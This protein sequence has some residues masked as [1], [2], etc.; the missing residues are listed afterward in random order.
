MRMKRVKSPDPFMSPV[1]FPRRWTI[2]KRSSNEDR[3]VRNGR[4][5]GVE[6]RVSGCMVLV[7]HLIDCGSG[8][9]LL[10]ALGSNC[11]RSHP[12][13]LG[14]LTGPNS[15]LLFFVPCQA[16][17]HLGRPLRLV[18]VHF[19]IGQVGWDPL[20]SGFLFRLLRCHHSLERVPGCAVPV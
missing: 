3:S 1:R 12:F 16:G 13:P 15:R 19:M 11:I 17:R 7:S 4:P 14:S 2:F 6:V 18:L 9:L 5:P 10:A 8:D 20:P